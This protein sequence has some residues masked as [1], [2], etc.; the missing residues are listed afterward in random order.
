MSN[1]EKC[2]YAVSVIIIAALFFAIASMYASCEI[3]GGTIV[4]T[5]TWTKCVK[6]QEIK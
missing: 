4:R 6:L 5:L 2:F 3:K 1:G